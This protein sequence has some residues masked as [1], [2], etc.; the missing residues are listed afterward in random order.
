MTR[1]LLAALVIAATGPL[2][3]AQ[4]PAVNYAQP[5]AALVGQATDIT[6]FG[7]NLAAPTAIW[8]NLASAKVEL[9]PGIEGNG[10][11]ADQV[12]YRCTLATDAPVGVYAFRVATA[13]GVSNTRLLMIDDLPNA[14]DNGNNK[15]M[16]TAQAVTFPTAIDGAAEAESYDFF[17]LTLPSG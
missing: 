17:K 4:P 7:G 16:A 6:L 15:T 5:A 1:F 14:V 12:V 9:A 8:T 13:K 10:T 3:S 2:V 11:K